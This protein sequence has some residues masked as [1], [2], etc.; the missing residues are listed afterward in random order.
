MVDGRITEVGSYQQLIENNGHFGEFLK[1]YDESKEDSSNDEPGL[2]LDKKEY[3]FF[4]INILQHMFKLV[5][6]KVSVL[7]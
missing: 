5:L 6:K 1:T 4:I 7:I 2:K 3:L